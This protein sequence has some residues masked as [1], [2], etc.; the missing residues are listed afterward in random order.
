MLS[1]LLGVS[2]LAHAYMRSLTKTSSI[3]REHIDTV[4]STGWRIPEKGGVDT[5]MIDTLMKEL[6]TQ[7]RVLVPD[8]RAYNMFIRF[9]DVLEFDHIIYFNSP[10]FRPDFRQY[11]EDNI[12]SIATLKAAQKNENKKFAR[13]TKYDLPIS[14]QIPELMSSKSSPFS[15]L[16]RNR[17]K[18]AIDEIFKTVQRFVMDFLE[19]E[20]GLKKTGQGF[21]KAFSRRSSR[22]NSLSH[23]NIDAE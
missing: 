18:L 3:V 23:F 1:F 21:K 9:Q 11:L 19:R 4:R 8:W 16:L 6:L 14:V 5:I 7:K 15:E 2:K 20:Y 12:Q 13:L 22:S 17:Q 10:D